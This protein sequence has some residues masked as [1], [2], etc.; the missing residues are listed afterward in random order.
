M[1]TTPNLAEIIIESVI[2]Y[3]SILDSIV[4]KH[5]LLFNSKFWSSWCYFL[6]IKQNLFMALHPQ[7][8]DQTEYQNSTIEAYFCFY[9][10][11]EQNNWARLLPITKFVY[12]NAKNVNTEFT[13]FKLSSG[14]QP[15]VSYKDDIDFYC[16]SKLAN[17]LSVK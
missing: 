3:H 13:P 4:S 17:K 15:Q 2:W 9:V 6:G 5:K 16:K 12:N 10:N 8:D 11:Y 7:T 1:I 14:Y